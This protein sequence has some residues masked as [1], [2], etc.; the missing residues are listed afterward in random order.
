MR[1]LILVIALFSIVL[2]AAARAT[3]PG[4]T[5]AAP[6]APVGQAPPVAHQEIDD[7]DD[8][9]V[10][11]QIAVLATVF[12]VVFVLGTILY[13]VRRRAGLVPPP[14]DPAATQD[15]H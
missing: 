5:S 10:E 11:V 6:Y 4:A 2:A 15:H 9:R 12:G 1:T 14:P 8:T 3:P 7:N 13:F